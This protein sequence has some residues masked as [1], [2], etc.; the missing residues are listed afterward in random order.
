MK[1]LLVLLLLTTLAACAQKR[2]RS[3]PAAQT[4]TEP[5]TEIAETPE[6]AMFTDVLPAGATKG[7]AIKIKYF[8]GIW[9][10]IG[11]GTLLDAAPD[12]E[13]ISGSGGIGDKSAS[14]Y[15]LIEDRGNNRARVK[16]EAS[17]QA[18]EPFDE[19]IDEE[20]TYTKE[21]ST[22]TFNT[23]AAVIQQS[24]FAQECIFTVCSGPGFQVYVKTTEGMEH[25]IRFDL[26]N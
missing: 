23:P 15:L 13:E 11:T 9:L 8:K 25:R 21:G 5:T 14:V 10:P 7:A 19:K 26:S 20:T 12:R 24:N 2:D 4:E 6:P 18:D 3:A 1:K 16:F 17:G 22:L